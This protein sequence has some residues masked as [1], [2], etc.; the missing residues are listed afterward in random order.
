MRPIGPITEAMAN[1]EI[2]IL[3]VGSGEGEVPKLH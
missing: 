3:P 2:F 1:P